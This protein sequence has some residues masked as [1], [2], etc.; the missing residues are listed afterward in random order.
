MQPSVNEQRAA[1]GFGL[2]IPCHRIPKLG[3]GV[4]LTG[5]PS[6]VRPK[7]VRIPNLGSKAGLPAK[8]STGGCHGNTRRL[9]GSAPPPPPASRLPGNGA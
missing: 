6:K 9:S 7:A 3:G 8:F 5:F 1:F 2:L 4:S